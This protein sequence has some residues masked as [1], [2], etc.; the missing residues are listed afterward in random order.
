MKINHV[1][2]AAGLAFI[3]GL[4][5]AAS[6]QTRTVYSNTFESREL[7][8]NWSANTKLVTWN[9][10]FTTFNGNYS[11]G[12]T[13]LNIRAAERP[14]NRNGSTG[15]GTGGGTG[16]GSGGGGAAR[17]GAGPALGRG[18]PPRPK[19]GSPRVC[20]PRLH[21]DAP[22]GFATPTQLESG[23]TVCSAGF[24]SL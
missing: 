13:E 18:G 19:A 6:A 8:Y 7:G 17:R 15:S 12:W 14:V 3:A 1:A 21:P 16:G 22:S 4:T 23:P 20:S 24:R 9:P 5:S 10:S 11:S 2:I